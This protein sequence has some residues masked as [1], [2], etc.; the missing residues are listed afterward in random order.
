MMAGQAAVAKLVKAA[1]SNPAVPNGACGF[2]SHPPYPMRSLIEVESVLTLASEGLNQSEIARRTGIPR[3]TV[4]DWVHGGAPQRHA[5][6]AWPANEALAGPRQEYSYLL[7]MYLGDGCLSQH[8]R[9]VH[10]LRIK[11]DAAYPGIVAECAS[12]MGAVLPNRVGIQ[13][14]PVERWKEVGAYSVHWAAL[15]PQHGP[16]LKHRRSIE[17]VDWQQRIVDVHP[18]PFLRGLIHSD[19][20]RGLNH[21]NGKGYPRYMFS[22]RS[23]DIQRLFCEACDRIGVRWTQSYKWSISVARRPDV[24]RLDEF[25]GPKH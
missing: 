18:R 22:N 9:G 17:L 11:L 15:F 25:I 16:G 6:P 10:R 13:G 2:E 24:A 5:P 3:A 8:P 23:R 7:G 14:H 20:T 21:V 4:R 1:G 12:A 19:G